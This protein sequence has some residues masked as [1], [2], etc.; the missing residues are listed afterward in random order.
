MNSV[1][2]EL[3]EVRQQMQDSISKKSDV[4]ENSRKQINHINSL[5]YVL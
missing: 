2:S 3:S 1:G 5:V 4:M